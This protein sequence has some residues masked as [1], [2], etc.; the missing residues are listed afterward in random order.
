MQDE[1]ERRSPDTP[2]VAPILLVISGP[3]GV[4]KDA[5]VA[6]LRRALPSAH[7]ATTVTTRPP[8]PGERDGVDYRFLSDE[9]YDRL[10]AG[11]GLLERASVYSHRYGVPKGAVR[12]ALRNGQDVVVR[13]DVQGAATIKRLLPDAILVFLA[14]ESREEL[15]TRLRGRATDGGAD[16][17]LRIDTAAREMAQEDA[18]DYVVVNAEGRL[19]E[20][21][22][23]IASIVESEKRRSGRRAIQI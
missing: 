4:G 5:V 1:T 10:V 20:A 13:V 19:D 17:R 12:D 6:D 3:S 9:Q 21:V 14:P 8:R 15:E 16:L 18:F 23:S 2:S 7:F 11:D 22:S